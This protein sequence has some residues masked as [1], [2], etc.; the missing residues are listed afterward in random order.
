[1][2]G[3][4]AKWITLSEEE[5]SMLQIFALDSDTIPR[6]A[7][8]AQVLLAMSDKTTCVKNLATR[9]D[10]TRSAVWRLCRRFNERRLDVL[11]DAPRPGRPRVHG[12]SQATVG[13]ETP[14]ARRSSV[15][16]PVAPARTKR[17]VGVNP[18]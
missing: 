10:I 8:R 3:R 5:R 9:L 2:R 7:R 12:Y 14:V 1:M 4:Q 11:V 18:S 17:K 6:I 15:G 16:E 13:V